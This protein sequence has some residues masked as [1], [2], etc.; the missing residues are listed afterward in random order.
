NEPRGEVDGGYGCV[1]GG[2]QEEKGDRKLVSPFDSG[3]GRRMIGRGW[4]RCRSSGG[5]GARDEEERGK[6]GVAWLPT[7]SGVLP[8]E[9]TLVRKGKGFPAKRGRD[10]WCRRR[11]ERSGEGGLRQLR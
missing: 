3:F 7:G 5:G 1:S 2:L 9:G 10:Q 4:S 11:E 8:G 6:K